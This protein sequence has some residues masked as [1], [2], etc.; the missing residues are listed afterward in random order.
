MKKNVK[1]GCG[2]AKGLV[3]LS[4]LLN[5]AAL[6]LYLTN[7]TNK[8]CPEMRMSCVAA[9]GI[10]AGLGG[11]LLLW[12]LLKKRMSTLACYGMYIAGLVGFAEYIV[13]QLNYI[14]NVFYGVDGNSFTTVMI[15]TAAMSLLGWVL[16]LVA[17][18]K[19][20]RDAYQRDLAA[21]EGKV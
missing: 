15:A 5:A 6:V 8:L 18:N 21:M 13:S 4:T 11:L 16:S 1:A 17:A 10:A 9:L 12:S 19:L 3:L 7:G 20:R 14:A 2:V